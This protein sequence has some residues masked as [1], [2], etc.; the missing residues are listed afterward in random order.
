MLFE[1]HGIAGVVVNDSY[2]FP[3]T[4][5]T[6]GVIAVKGVASTTSTCAARTEASTASTRTTTSHAT[7][8]MGLRVN[9]SVSGTL[10]ATTKTTTRNAVCWKDT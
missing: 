10:S 3:A 8:M 5:V 7:A 2:V 6:T 1:D 9:T 4:Q